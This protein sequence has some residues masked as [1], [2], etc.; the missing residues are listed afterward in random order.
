M[1]ATRTVT[2]PSQRSTRRNV[3][4][5]LP[6]AFLVFFLSTKAT[7]LVN[8]GKNS[9]RAKPRM[10]VS[11]PHWIDLCRSFTTITRM[12]SHGASMASP[13]IVYWKVTP[14]WL[15]VRKSCGN[16][17]D[18]CWMMQLPKGFCR[19]QNNLQHGRLT[20]CYSFRVNCNG[21]FAVAQTD[22]GASCHGSESW[23]CLFIPFP[24]SPRSSLQIEL[25]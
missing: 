9:N 8:Y 17:P 13:L 4:A 23:F 21:D 6:T 22:L 3:K 15:K 16:V 11:L 25:G 2:I 24:P 1:P 5:A 7:I 19:D 14:V 10:R 18:L 12:A 20:T